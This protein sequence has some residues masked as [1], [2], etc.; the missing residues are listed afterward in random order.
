MLRL[1]PLFA[2]AL[3]AICAF[4]YGAEPPAGK[5]GDPDECPP[6]IAAFLDASDAAREVEL[7]E[8]RRAKGGDAKA[9]R[10]RMHVG[11]PPA[12]HRALG[13]ARAALAVLLAAR[14]TARPT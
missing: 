1:R 7:K 9:R 12:K 11:A 3:F 5:D 6:K 2:S 10:R 4:G 14:E 8:L 13:D